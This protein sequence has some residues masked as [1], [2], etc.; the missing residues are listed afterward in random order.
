MPAFENLFRIVFSGTFVCMTLLL[1]VPADACPEPTQLI[2]DK[3]KAIGDLRLY[4]RRERDELWQFYDQ[5]IESTLS[6]LYEN[7]TRRRA[8]LQEAI[9]KARSENQPERAD[10]LVAKKQAERKQLEEE[11]NSAKTRMRAQRHE[12]MTELHAQQKAERSLRREMLQMRVDRARALCGIVGVLAGKDK[13][14]AKAYMDNLY[15]VLG[16][17]AMPDAD[18]PLTPKKSY[19]WRLFEFT[20]KHFGREQP[21]IENYRF[22]TGIRG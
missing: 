10:A 21:D 18:A 7:W 20:S 17:R 9:G 12:E 3:R 13:E 5:Q 15:A 14:R 2:Q 22:G 16:P 11:V 6:P 4:Q 1:A 8:R 19:L